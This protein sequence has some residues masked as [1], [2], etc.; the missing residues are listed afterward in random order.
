MMSAIVIEDNFI[1][2]TRVIPPVSNERSI[3]LRLWI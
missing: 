2:A 1:V 3:P